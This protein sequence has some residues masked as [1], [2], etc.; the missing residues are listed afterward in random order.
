MIPYNENNENKDVK[1]LAVFRDRLITRRKQM[2][3]S[4]KQLAER[5]DIS[6]ASL[7]AYEKGTKTPTL[8]V[9]VRLS[10]ALLVS[11]DWLCGL[12]DYS[13]Q[14]RRDPLNYRELF[15]MMLSI[16]TILP[17]TYIGEDKDISPGSTWES[18]VNEDT[19]YG[20]VTTYSVGNAIISRAV[21]EYQE[22][23]ALRQSNKISNS[24]FKIWLEGKLLELEKIPLPTAD[25]QKKSE[26][27]GE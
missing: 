24:I 12:K 13:S 2:G 10:R 20:S 21:K 5:C 11:I 22:M 18:T 14:I 26:I 23:L 16:K 25:E 6:P 17:K 27:G 15:E 7:S 1:E 8:G 4:Q 19:G 9:A 3:L